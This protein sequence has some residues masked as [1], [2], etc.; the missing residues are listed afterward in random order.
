[1]STPLMPRWRYIVLAVVAAWTL[2]LVSSCA[3]PSVVADEPGTAADSHA[4]YVV[5]YG[6]HTGIVFRPPD[7]PDGSLPS[8]PGIAPASYLEVGW[9]E[10]RYYPNPDPGTGSLLRAALWPT[11]SVVHVT[12]LQV[13][14]PQAYRMRKQVQLTVSD[15]ELVALATFVRKSLTVRDGAALPAADS[16]L[17]GS[18]FYR[19]PL[20]YHVFNNCNHWAAAALR[21]AGCNTHPRY[22][23][24]VDRVM[25][26]ARAC[27]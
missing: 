10:A 20:R 7:L 9:G 23:L 6:W 16:W 2:V 5:E 26:Q 12:P 11:R 27:E 14:P 3:L 8:F 25:R 18:R 17:E 13:A 19:S 15:A 4:V 21:A 24:T 1:M 22:T